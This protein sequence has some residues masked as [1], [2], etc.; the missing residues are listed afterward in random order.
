MDVAGNNIWQSYLI[1]RIS[2]QSDIKLETV[3]ISINKWHLKVALS[4]AAERK[5]PLEIAVQKSHVGG[6]RLS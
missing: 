4:I 5:S 2:D 6:S 3:K 1:T